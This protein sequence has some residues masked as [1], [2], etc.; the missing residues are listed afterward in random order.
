MNKIGGFFSFEMLNEEENN[1][2]E[3]LYPIE[4]DIRYLMSGRCAIYYALE[5][6]KLTDKKQVAYVP[7]YTCET[8]LDP[9]IKAGYQLIF[10][11]IDR[12]MR[13]IF[14]YSLID[15]ISVISICGYYGFCNYDRNFVKIC[16]DRGVK[17]IEDATHSIFSSDGINPYCDYVVGS[18]RKWIGVPSGG[19]AIKTTG[20]FSLSL[21]EP[22]ETHLAMRSN[23][24]TVKKNILKNPSKY[25]DQEL[26]DAN[27]IFWDAE[28]MLRKIFDSYRSDEQ[29]V[30]IMK[31][32][33]VQS[34]IEKRRSNYQYL[35][36]NIAH[37]AR[38]EI[39]FPV[40]PKETVPSHFT[41]YAKDRNTIQKFLMENGVQTTAYWPKGPLINL[42][43]HD[44][45]AYI[46]DHVLS[47][48]CDQR[49]D[50]KDMQYICDLLKFI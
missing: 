1:F 38:L 28:L 11:G 50:L 32:F 23:S 7:I 30:F 45:A 17:V 20:K 37:N 18:L 35:L 25:N 16:S 44:D 4:G 43:G 27:S 49:Y 46:Y 48:P 12:D 34:L 6:L 21:I 5:D 2:F 39:I 15:K 36:D 40:L 10:Y 42:D 33:D 26:I 14:D 22:D 9:F 24:M 8:V 19:F 29:S 47:I 3:N 31:H 13:P 41:I